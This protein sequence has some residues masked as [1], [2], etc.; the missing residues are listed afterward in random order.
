M[1]FLNLP[2]IF[3]E[4]SQCVL[5]S[6]ILE[7]TSLHIHSSDNEDLVDR[8]MSKRLAIPSLADLPSVLSAPLT[9]KISINQSTY[10]RLSSTTGEDRCSEDTIQS[11]F[12][13][14]EPYENFYPFISTIFDS[15]LRHYEKANWYFFW[16][17][18]IYERFLE[19]LPRGTSNRYSDEPSQMRNVPPNYAFVLSNMCLFRGEEAAP[20]DT[21]DL[22][23]R[24]SAKVNWIY[25]FAPYMLGYCCK[26]PNMTFVALTPPT[27]SQGGRPT[28]HELAT[29]DLR[30]RRSRIDN[31]RHLINLATILPLLKK[32]VRSPVNDWRNFDPKWENDTPN[33]FT[34][35]LTEVQVERLR[36]VHAIL[37]EHR[38]PN[39]DALTFSK[40][41]S[42]VQPRRSLVRPQTEKELR[43]CLRCILETLR[44]A[45][46]IPLYHCNVR[47]EN[48]L[49][50]DPDSHKWILMNWENAASESMPAKTSTSGSLPSPSHSPLVF[51][52]HEAEM[53][54]WSVWYLIQTCGI[55]DISEEVIAIGEQVRQQS[56]TLS[57]D[58]V[59]TLIAALPVIN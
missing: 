48:V 40:S 31:M 36:H 42:K 3:S 5:V 58:D 9:D 12:K 30:W 2:A 52:G 11:V 29:F 19:L 43:E 1:W 39:T 18:N 16:N 14:G 38:V 53:D 37:N 50:E 28:V 54:I 21:E 10:T 26:G 41:N 55:Q 44:V 45:H 8:W 4:V 7:L 46:S 51:D 24:M 20:W 13:I 27:G 15:P 25:E 35:T 6:M 47:W 57:A 33:L 34:R 17:R 22:M 49:C 23:L 59:Y 32:L 56:Q